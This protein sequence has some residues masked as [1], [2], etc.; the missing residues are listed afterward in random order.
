MIA[1]RL[2]ANEKVATGHMFRC[3]AI[4]KELKKK[5][6]VCIFFVAE[7]GNYD[8]IKENGF[9]AC[10]LPLKYDNWNEGIDILTDTL[11]DKKASALVVDSYLVTPDFFSTVSNTL[12]VFYLDDLCREKYDVAGVLHYSEWDGENTISKLYENCSTKV[13]SG[14]KYMPLR[15]GFACS[16]KRPVYDLLITTGGSDPYHVT[17]DLLKKIE[18]SDFIKN[19][20]ICAVLGRMNPDAE[21]IK[22]KYSDNENITVLWNISNMN[23]II[24]QSRFGVTAGGTTVYELMAGGVLYVCFAF[25]DDQDIFG[26]KL[27]E[28]GHCKYAGDVRVDKEETEVRILNTLKELFSLSDEDADAILTKNQK[29]VDGKGCER[30]ANAII[31]II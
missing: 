2:D 7:G 22:K 10:S 16:Q 28:H 24:A 29:T 31:D 1:F 27:E 11:K 9:E 4:A 25:S 20:K 3:V 23:E 17:L 8:Y 5:G 19:K 13:Y 6:H 12:P 26:K 30:I 15:E 21:E 14:M 18:S